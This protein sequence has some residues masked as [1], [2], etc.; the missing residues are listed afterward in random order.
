MYGGREVVSVT[1]RFDS[2]GNGFAFRCCTKAMKMTFLQLAAERSFIMKKKISTQKV[3]VLGLLTAL[4]VIFAMLT[5]YRAIP[6]MKF[7]LKF[8]PVFI[9]GVFYG[10]F[11]AGVISAVGDF[12]NASLTTGVNPMITGVEF[13]NG[14]IFGL[15]FLKAGENKFYYIRAAVCAFLQMIIALTIMSEILV[16]MGLS[17]NF[18]T[19]VAARLPEKLIIFVVQLAVMCVMKKVVFKLKK[20]LQRNVSND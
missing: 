9:A 20:S 19:A 18:A 13:L 6:L 11:S 15:C 1:K 10:P 3:C 17:P 16:A 8:I 4:S 7:S 5:T 14:F 2:C 12:I